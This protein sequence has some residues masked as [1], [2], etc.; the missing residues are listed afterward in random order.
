MSQRYVSRFSF[1]ICLDFLSDLESFLL[2]IAPLSACV[3]AMHVCSSNSISSKIYKFPCLLT[4][5]FRCAIKIIHT[6]MLMCVCV[7]WSVLAIYLLFTWM[8]FTFVCICVCVCAKIENS[9]PCWQDEMYYISY[10][11]YIIIWFW[12]EKFYTANF[13][14]LHSWLH[15]SNRS[16]GTNLHTHTYTCTRARRHASP[17]LQS[18]NRVI[19]NSMK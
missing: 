1:V 6:I 13:E 12:L 5:F 18:E 8:W 15:A 16:N 19:N 7:L 9:N 14:A 10:Y 3:Y 2:G 17:R 4:C 11:F